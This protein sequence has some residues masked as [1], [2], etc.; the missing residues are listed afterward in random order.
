M[1]YEVLKNIFQVIY[2]I[3]GL[4]TLADLF[5]WIGLRIC[6]KYNSAKKAAVAVIISFVVCALS[7]FAHLVVAFKMYNM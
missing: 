2:I 6:K 4:I 3:A 7:M 1:N 5:L